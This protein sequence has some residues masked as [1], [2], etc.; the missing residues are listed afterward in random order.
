M[1]DQHMDVLVDL[2]GRDLRRMKNRVFAATRATIIESKLRAVD[3][4]LPIAR[5]L[6]DAVQ[7]HIATDA[8]QRLVSLTAALAEVNGDARVQAIHDVTYGDARR[9]KVK[10]ALDAFLRDND[11]EVRVAIESLVV[12]HDASDSDSDEDV[13]DGGAAAGVVLDDGGAAGDVLEGAAAAVLIALRKWE[14]GVGLRVIRNA[15]LTSPN[16][17]PDEIARVLLEAETTY[18][19]PVFAQGLSDVKIDVAVIGNVMNFKQCPLWRHL[20]EYHTDSLKVSLFGL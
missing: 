2:C 13:E 1:S 6:A 17:A 12:G 15:L 4:T 8:P 18:L 5:R 3:A 20:R 9:A 16:I 10:A 19:A 7:A 11:G 14:Q